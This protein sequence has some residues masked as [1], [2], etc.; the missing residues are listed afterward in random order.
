LGRKGAYRGVEF[1]PNPFFVIDTAYYVVPRRDHDMRWLFYAIKHYKLGEIDDGSPIPS[2]TRA[3]VYPGQLEIP[4]HPEQRAIA[5]ILGTLDDKIELNQRMRGTIEA[6]A[7][8]LFKAWFIDFEPVRAKAE[9]RDPC[10]PPG[11]SALFPDRFIETEIGEIPA[12]WEVSTLGEHVLNFDSKRVPVSGAERAKQQ[13]PYPY[14]GAAGVMDHVD[15]FLFNGIYLL[16]GEDGSVTQ[17]NGLA[18]AQY[19]WGKFWVN[20]HAHVIQGKGSVSTE[21]VYLHFQF[22]PVAP[23]ITGAVQPKLSQGRMNVMPFV[24]AGAE[25]CKAFARVIEPWF[26]RLRTNAHESATLVVLRDALL[27]KLISGNIRVKDA[28]AFFDRVM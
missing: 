1:S 12:G 7:C 27:P 24:F 5:H 17:G 22:E 3:A 20:N 10:L 16:L 4:P 19:V 26:A 9:G 11:F 23:Y 2:T 18:V 25:V 6:M 8:A 14:Y 15:D 13:G 28:K 21:Q